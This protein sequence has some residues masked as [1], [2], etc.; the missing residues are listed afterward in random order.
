GVV[1]ENL[2]PSLLHRIRG[3]CGRLQLPLHPG[4]KFLLRFRNHPKRHVRM[5]QT[6]KLRAWAAI[7]ARAAGLNPLR[8]DARGNEIALA[9]QIWNPETVDYVVGSSADHHWTAHWNVDLIG[10]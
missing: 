1:H 5:L 4:I 3:R 6:A 8:G 2:L 7:H 9:M 10:S